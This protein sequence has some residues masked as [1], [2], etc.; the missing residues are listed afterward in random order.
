LVYTLTIMLQN[1]HMDNDCSIIVEN[2][3]TYTGVG[4]GL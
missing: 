1:L 4:I 3:S 2:S